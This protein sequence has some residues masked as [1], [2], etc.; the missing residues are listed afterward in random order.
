MSNERLRGALIT[1]NLTYDQ[2]SEKVGVDPKTVERWVSQDRVPHRTHRLKVAAILDTDDVLL[3]PST[4]GDPRTLAA[5]EAEFVT[6]YPN[7]G[8]VPIDL[9]I[10]LISQSAVQID[11]HAFS[12]SFL[13]DNVPDFD[14]LILD[15]AR[16]GVRVRLLLGDPES[17]AVRRRGEEEQIGDGL[18]G[19]C[20]LTWTYCKPFLD[21]PGIEARKHNA[22]LYS[23]LFRFDD[24]LMVNPHAYGAAASHSPVFHFQ[25]LAGGRLFPHY[26]SSL[27]RV[28][29]QATPVN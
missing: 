29:E 11:I 8:S 28:W 7:R 3:W 9:W 5:S 24:T 1:A 22:T 13:H 18:A 10:S 21:E 16:N 6:L 23:S 27:E 17:E 25:K 12:A 2:L 19:R 4:K 15:R 20:N 26:M 14:Q